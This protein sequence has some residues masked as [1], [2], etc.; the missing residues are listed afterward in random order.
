MQQ[1]AA[2]AAKRA[3]AVDH[4]SYFAFELINNLAAMTA[5]F[6]SHIGSGLMGVSDQNRAPRI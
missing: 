1:T 6:V 4:Q 3:V 5:A 2:L